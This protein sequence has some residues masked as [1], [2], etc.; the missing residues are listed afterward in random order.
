MAAAIAPKDG[1]DFEAAYL[2]MMI[3]HHQAGAPMWALAREKT[4][5]GEIKALEKKTTP[6]ERREIQE[7]TNWLKEWHQKT[8]QDFKEPS[9]SK[10]MMEKDMT[11]LRA[12]S[13]AE[14]DKLF[15]AKM[16]RHHMGAIQMGNLGAE[17]APHDEVKKS[18]RLIVESQT[19]DRKQ[20]LGIAEGAK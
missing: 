8:P 6:K 18:A 7:M 15:A 1:A 4:T 2:G 11:E 14:F 5:T 16:A 20:L 13:G 10:A 3:L 9:E 19:K 12:A 17:K